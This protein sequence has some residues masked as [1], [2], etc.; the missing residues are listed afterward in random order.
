[1]S[2]A[3]QSARETLKAHN[4]RWSQAAGDLKAQFS[5]SP[6]TPIDANEV[7]TPSTDRSSG[8][9]GSTRCICNSNVPVEGGLMLQCESCRNWLHAAC[10]G[11]DEHTVPPVYLCI[12]C[13]KTPAR[14]GRLR[15]HTQSNT[16]YGASPLSHKTGFRC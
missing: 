3:E 11:L 14:G 15:E 13:V 5:L 6:F 7:I 2:L 16:T 1:M 9:N 12:Y 4:K 8:S 10:I